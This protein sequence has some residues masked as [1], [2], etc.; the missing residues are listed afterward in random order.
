L[1]RAFS[2][3]YQH[4]GDIIVNREA[5]AG[6]GFDLLLPIDPAKVTRP[7]LQ[8]GLLEKLFT[9]FESAAGPVPNVLAA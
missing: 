4:G 3:A 2:I 5:P 1:L 9:H 6:P 7:D 8:E